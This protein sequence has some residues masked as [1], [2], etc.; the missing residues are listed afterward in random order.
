MSA[1]AD[2]PIAGDGGGGHSWQGSV[3]CLGDLKLQMPATAMQRRCKKRPCLALTFT[4]QG[5]ATSV[6]AGGAVQIVRSGVGNLAGTR[7]NT[8]RLQKLARGIYLKVNDLEIAG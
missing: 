7:D 2:A 1:E 4:R 3:N 8:S 6:A 5:G